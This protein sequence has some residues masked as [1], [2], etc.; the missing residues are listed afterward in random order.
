MDAII[1]QLSLFLATQ[2]DKLKL[3]SPIVFLVVQGAL[4]TLA[5]LI[6]SDAVTIPSPVLLI[7][8]G[9]NLDSFLSLLLI[10]IVALVAP[11]TTAIIKKGK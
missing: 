8:L 5:G 7:K 4:I 2:L 11:R 9:I 3:A 10:S 6:S 1:K